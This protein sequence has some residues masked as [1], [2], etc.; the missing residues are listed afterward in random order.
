M[1]RQSDEF[2]SVLEGV[3]KDFGSMNIWVAPQHLD[4]PNESNSIAAVQRLPRRPMLTPSHRSRRALDD[5]APQ[6]QALSQMEVD[7]SATSCASATRSRRWHMLCSLMPM[8]PRRPCRWE[9]TEA[10]SRP[11]RSFR[12][13]AGA[14]DDEPGVSCQVPPAITGEAFFNCTGVPINIPFA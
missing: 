5:I 12:E 8:W 13:K 7:T 6:P 3:G 9:W 4:G 10:W 1:V 11:S 14:H 2:Q